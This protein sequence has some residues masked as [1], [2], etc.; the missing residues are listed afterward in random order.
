MQIRFRRSYLFAAALIVAAL[1]ACHGG[2]D[3]NS[4]DAGSSAQ[5]ASAPA[6]SS[7]PAAQPPS[8]QAACRPDGAFT[9]SGSASQVAANNGTLAV[10]VVPSL[11]AD[12]Q[13]NRNFTAP[14]A[15]ASSQVQQA[16]G[17]FT[18]LAST[19]AATNCLGLNHGMVTEIQGSGTD[20]AIG[21]WIQAEDTDGNTYNPQQGL[22][23]AVGTPLS[24]P[25]T[26]GALVCTQ[27][28]ADTVADNISGP[29]GTLAATSATLDPVAGTLNNL[30]MSVNSNGGT[31]Y[32]LS[33][34]QV[35]LN[36]VSTS[37]QLSTQTVV[38]GHDASQPLVALGYS[39]G[40]IGGVVVLSC[41]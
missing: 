8:S 6:A 11:P 28:L 2:G 29:T 1:S 30:I 32:T 21:R 7:S 10:V 22:H 4:A 36:G 19:A 41:H 9:Y 27:L 13:K 18:T 15:P 40:T 33:S 17:G 34:P 14:A 38:V 31:T 37:G 3:G 5:S 20:V 26:G 24:L 25:R 23:Y 16:G 12:F 35:T 39:N